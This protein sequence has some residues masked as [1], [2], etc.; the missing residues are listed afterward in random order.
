MIKDSKK[1][2]PYLNITELSHYLSG[3]PV[4]TIYKWTA[5]KR[6]TGFPA[7]KVGKHLRF[8]MS[9]VDDWIRKNDRQK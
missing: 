3:I 9:E 1:P 8:K 6:I 7:H 5:K 2:E 4:T